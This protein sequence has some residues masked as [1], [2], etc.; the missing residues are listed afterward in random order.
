V[1]DESRLKNS[2]KN[3]IYGLISQ[4]VTL[5]LSFAVRT[6][7]IRYLDKE[8]LGVNGLFSNILTI[9]SLSELGFGTA[10]VYSM[11]KPLAN[12]NTKKLQALMNVYAK[13][14]TII[15]I[16]VAIIGVGIIPFMDYIIKEKLEIN[17]LTVIY[18]MFLANSVLSYFWGYKRSILSAD[19]KE[20]ICS[21]YRYIFTTVKSVLEICILVLTKNFILY[22]L[23]QILMTLAENIFISHKVD[24]LYPFL[25]EKN[26][27]KLQESEMKRIKED[28]KALCLT[29]FGHVML[30][31]TDNI[32][33]SSFVGVAWVGLLS[34]YTLI[35][36]AIVMILSQI[37][38][39]I[40]GS[41]GNYIA[42]ENKKN[43]YNLFKVVD[44]TNFW[45][46]GFSTVALIILLN[47]FIE[48]WIGKEYVLNEI[49][50]I[51]L[52]VN[53]LI[54]GIMTSLW[55]FR[56]TM[57]LFIQGKY[58]PIIAAI[59]NILI[60]IILAKYLGIVGV[61]LGTTI[62]RVF[63]NLWFDSYIIYKYGFEKK[64][65]SY[66]M[67][68]V[69]R[70]ILIALISSAIYFVQ[71]IIFHNCNEIFSFIMLILICMILPNC[72]FVLIYRNKL[73]FKFIRDTVNSIFGN[74]ILDKGSKIKGD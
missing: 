32:I 40:T 8:Y 39:G 56:S 7:F 22:L 69:F 65:K 2:V 20:Y 33:I 13:V 9:I 44:F 57:G 72:I 52:S 12:K 1:N 64:V 14:Y 42:K 55:T 19:Q 46:Y 11:Y 66:Y 60:S 53:F 70:F 41:I 62:S 38:S 34:N 49:T 63:V 50:I 36:G 58:R 15:G 5:I 17:H 35:T 71:Y 51:V 47:P 29:K 18:L 6:F 67:T 21:Q 24:K 28:V 4:F 25:K 16:I 37:S 73:E 61:L 10:M 68:Y 27:E 3:T 45:I 23:V 26:N 30:N 48:L 54:N 59:L 43:Q 74:L 31:G